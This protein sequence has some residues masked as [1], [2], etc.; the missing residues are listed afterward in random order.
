M[1]DLAL[2]G[3]STFRAIT[4]GDRIQAEYKFRD[5]FEFTPY[6]RLVFSAN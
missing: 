5:S 3:T 1:P 2:A 4:G 6:A